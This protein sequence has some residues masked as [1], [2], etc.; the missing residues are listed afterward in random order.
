M[1][2][3]EHDIAIFKVAM[4][5]SKDQRNAIL[6]ETARI[7]GTGAELRLFGSRVDDNAG[8]GDI[9]LRIEANGTAAELLDME[10]ELRARLARRLGERRIDIVVHVRGQRPRPID[11]HARR[12]GIVL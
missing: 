9:D 2:F 12:T 1:I 7:F 8:G 3:E 5:L 4:R 10:L 6:E 11:E